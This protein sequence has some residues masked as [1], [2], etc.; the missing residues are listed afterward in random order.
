[1]TH[2]GTLSALARQSMVIIRKEGPVQFLRSVSAFIGY[3][4][5][6]IACREKYYLYEHSIV[7]RDCEQY[8]P[9]LDSWELRIIHSNEEADT[10]AVEGF[11]DLRERF[12]SAPRRFDRGAV[13]FCV[14]AGRE[15][16]HVGWLA[17]DASGKGAVNALPY[18][19]AFE[20]GQAWTGLT[21]TMPRFRGLGLMQY[22]YYE[23]FE[24]LRSRGFASSRNAVEISNV[25]SQKAHARFNPLI[26]GV[27]HFRKFLWWQSWRVEPLPEG[28]CRGRPPPFSVKDNETGRQ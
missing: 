5:S 6:R 7:P 26:Y 24:Y 12:V 11:E 18:D 21:Y 8:V 19:V 20:D 4:G 25:A 15:L 14:F 28:P 27:G 1:M 3:L 10:V 22:G 2:M 9:R 17:L 23:R 16:A 13:A